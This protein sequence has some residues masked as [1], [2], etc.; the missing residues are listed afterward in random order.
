MARDPAQSVGRKTKDKNGY[1]VVSK[2][3]NRHGG[4]TIYIHNSINYPIRHNLTDDYM[5]LKYLSQNLSLF[6]INS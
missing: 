5:H 1:H 2:D 3:R 6:L 4:G